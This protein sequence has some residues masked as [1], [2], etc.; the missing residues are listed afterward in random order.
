M[1]HTSHTDHSEQPHTNTHHKTNETHET[2]NTHEDAH[3]NQ[4]DTANHIVT[5]Q[6]CEGDIIVT[7]GLEPSTP[8]MPIGYVARTTNAILDLTRLNHYLP[9]DFFAPVVHDPAL[10][11]RQ[12]ILE[13]D[14]FYILA[15]REAIRIPP[16]Y[17]MEVIPFSHHM[18][19]LRAHYA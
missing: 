14:K 6:Y 10:P 8:T 13:K 15:T 16:S 4:T 17:S 1:H 5:P 11:P 9:H 7:L 3:N 19:E 12:L 18:G 2:N